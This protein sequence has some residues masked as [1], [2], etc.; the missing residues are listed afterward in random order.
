MSGRISHFIRLFAEISWFMLCRAIS[1]MMFTLVWPIVPLILQLI[2][3]AYWLASTVLLSTTG[4]AEFY[5]NDSNPA[6]EVVSRIPCDPSV[7]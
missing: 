7:S 3:F 6:S 2:V 5:R 1:N 4:H